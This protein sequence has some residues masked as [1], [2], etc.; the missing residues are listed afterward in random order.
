M[1]EFTAYEIAEL[2]EALDLDIH[3]HL[4]EKLNKAFNEALFRE[5]KLLTK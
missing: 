5:A 1:I 2:L 3:G 4:I